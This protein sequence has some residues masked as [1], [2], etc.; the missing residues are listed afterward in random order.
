MQIKELLKNK[1]FK[2]IN[3]LSKVEKWQE[4]ALEVC[5]EFNITRVSVFETDKTGKERLVTKNYP[6]I[7]FRHACNNLSYLQG[8]VELVRERFNGDVQGKGHY[9]ISLF[10]KNPPWKK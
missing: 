7:I 8:K 2:Q 10:R 9:L 3:K 4:Y 5:K 6:A 1:K